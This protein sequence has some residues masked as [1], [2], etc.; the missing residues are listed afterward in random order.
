MFFIIEILNDL[1][2]FISKTKFFEGKIWEETV[3]F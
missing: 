3:K 1:V 2:S